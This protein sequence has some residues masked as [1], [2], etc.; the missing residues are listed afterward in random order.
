MAPK[1]TKRP[2]ADPPKDA[3]PAAEVQWE[4]PAGAQRVAIVQVLGLADAPLTIRQ[5]EEGVSKV[6]PVRDAS[7]LEEQVQSLLTVKHIAKVP[8]RK[9]FELTE[10][11]RAMFESVRPFSKG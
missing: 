11:G 1:A 6:V 2:A 5:I 10:A 8:Q 9:V 7:A 4:H 3:P